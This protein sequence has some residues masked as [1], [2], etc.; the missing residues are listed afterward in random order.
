MCSENERTKH[1]NTPGVS[2]PRAETPAAAQPLWRVIRRPQRR[3]STRSMLPPAPKPNRPLI[4]RTSRH[5]NQQTTRPRICDNLLCLAPDI[6]P[7]LVR[8]YF[9]HVRFWWLLLNH[10]VVS[11]HGSHRKDYSQNDSQKAQRPP[12]SQCPLTTA[13]S[14]GRCNTSVKSLCRSFKFQRLTWPFV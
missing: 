11:F 13:S 5:P 1:C 6:S 14:A 2:R 8:V 3:H 4:T 7:R 10:L 12:V 9:N